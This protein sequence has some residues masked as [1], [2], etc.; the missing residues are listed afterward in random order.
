MSVTVD[1][2]NQ[3][4]AFT[5]KYGDK[6]V[7]LMQIGSFYEIYEWVATE[8]NDS[9]EMERAA[10]KTIGLAREAAEIF[11]RVLTSKNKS[12]PHS[13]T[14]PY[15][16]GFPIT[17]CDQ[18]VDVLL[19]ADYTAI[20]CDQLKRPDGTIERKVVEI[21]SPSTC[22]DSVDGGATIAN[23]ATNQIMSIYLEVQRPK[24]N[25][26][27]RSLKECEDFLITCG[28]AWADVVTG[29]SAVSEALNSEA[30][31]AFALQ[32]LHRFL[33]CQAPRE[34]IINVKRLPE[35]LTELYSRFLRERLELDRIPTVLIH[36]NQVPADYFQVKYQQQFLEK[37]FRKN[38]TPRPAVPIN[39]KGL[40]LLLVPETTPESTN[41]IEDLDLER[42][43]FGI[44]SYIILLQYVY[45]HNEVILDH[46]TKPDVSWVSA[47]E[48]LVLLHNASVQLHLIPDRARNNNRRRGM[49]RAEKNR[50]LLGILDMTETVSGRRFLSEMLIRPLHAQDQIELY[51]DQVGELVTRT[52]LLSSINGMLKSIPDLERL[53]RR[54]A[55]GIIKPAEL[56]LLFR[57]AYGTINNLMK[58]LRNSNTP[59]LQKLLPDEK[60][61][62]EFETCLARIAHQI[63]YDILEKCSLDVPRGMSGKVTFDAP[64]SFLRP[65]I[66]EELDRMARN[67][68]IRED[69][70]NAIV[71]HL[72]SFLTKTRGRLIEIERNGAKKSSGSKTSKVS[73]LPEISDGNE[74][75]DEE[76]I[77]SGSSI[78]F[79]YTT[80]AKGKT[81]K[82]NAHRIDTQRCGR[83]EIRPWKSAAIIVTSDKI[84]VCCV[85]LENTRV[86]LMQALHRR[87]VGI[88]EYINL[89]HT[90]FSPIQRF[91]GMLDYVHSNALC[92]IKYKYF[93]PSIDLT[94][95]DGRSYVELEE[96]RHPLVERII[97][98]EYIPNDLSLGV[99]GSYGGMLL[100]GLNSSGKTTLAKMVGALVV[101]AQCG[102]WVPAKMRFRPYTKIVTRL[103]GEDNL[104][105]GRSSF[106]MEM[107]E[108]RTVL[109]NADLNT[110]VICDEIS[111]GTESLSASGI[112]IATILTLLNRRSSFILSTHLHNLPT[113][114][115]LTSLDPS[116][117]RI[118]HL[119]TSYNEE[120]H[121]LIYERKLRDGQGSS[122]YGIEVAKSL[123]LDREFI[124]MANDVRKS[125]GELSPMVLSTK[126]SRYNANVYVDAC[127]LCGKKSN[128]ETHHLKE[129]ATAAADGFIADRFHKNS[130]FNL[131]VLCHTCHE[132]LHRAGKGLEVKQTL[133]GKVLMV[134]PDETK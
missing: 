9:T 24:R 105:S 126:K 133:N 40:R 103:T 18:Y 63:D 42:Y 73:R 28:I 57:Q 84:E 71:A 43:Y 74:D 91:I 17:A 114:S 110:L 76:D 115:Y 55:L 106:V 16:T 92:T 27:V 37:I 83:I 108:L 31:T 89:T 34:V 112:T 45:E 61:S 23:G 19:G 58:L 72:N 22:M 66:D 98:C 132:S 47:E 48:H 93:R 101:M 96:A 100:Y 69:E 134:T 33:L 56:V 32:E 35:N 60:T 122:L 65:N 67:L 20:R 118:C 86:A 53:H 77:T 127:T 59:M 29:K 50:S 25:T 130:E 128:L 46:I 97:D 39:N 95:S 64:A 123:D 85:D 113:T 11:N 51:Y 7:L 12:L 68:M 81:L 1:Y 80:N 49:A 116:S 3:Q 14:N 94:K 52:D 75:E 4:E 21:L 124:N 36:Y 79:L 41:I 120:L 102:M 70:L 78:P 90:F 5:K 82:D 104:L 117:L 30:D 26:G 13:K 62:L 54:L 109:R 99:S 87:Y 111:R 6:T 88:I 119:T 131:T 8:A 129:Q 15:M 38:K 125:L 107:M 44:V 2:L 121:T 10:K